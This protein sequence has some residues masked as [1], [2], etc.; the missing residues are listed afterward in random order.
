MWENAGPLKALPLGR[1]HPNIVRAHA[2][3]IVHDA[4]ELLRLWVWQWVQQRGIHYAE[5]RGRRS[6]TQR[7]RQDRDGGKPGRLAQHAQRVANVPPEIV[8]PQP[9]TGFVKALLSPRDVAESQACRGL[10][11]LIAEPLFLQT[12]G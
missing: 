5:D 8:P 9:V 7:N 1:R 11:L 10:G 3:K 2:R 6:N 4:Y 12:L